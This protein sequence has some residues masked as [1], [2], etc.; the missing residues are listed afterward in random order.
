MNQPN[1]FA[2]IAERI[3]ADAAREMQLRPLGGGG[4]FVPQTVGQMMELAKMMA[5][6]G[7][8]VR[9]HL[10]GNP[11]ACLGICMQAARWE[12]DPYAV[13][14]K[15]FEVND[16]LGYESQLIAAVVNTRAPIKGRLKTRFH[17]DGDARRCIVSGTFAGEDEP[18]EVES[19][20]IGRIHPKNSP[21]WKSDPDQQLSYYT[22]RLWARREC[23]EVLLGVYDV[24]ELAAIQNHHGAQYA[25]DVTPPRPTRDQFLP[26]GDPP[27]MD[28]EFRRATGEVVLDDPEESDEGDPAHDPETGEVLQDAPAD[29]PPPAD[30][31]PY[32]LRSAD[33]KERAQ[34]K[35]PLGFVKALAGE[36]AAAGSDGARKAIIEANGHD[37]G[38]AY[39]D[40]GEDV[41]KR[42]NALY[43]PAP[44]G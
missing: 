21:L 19:P 8:T 44:E 41:Q 12:M 1:A 24:D 10:R 29:P 6:G 28:R 2:R 33:G 34:F 18:T 17:G 15:S 42:V 35:A 39:S 31:G 23:P 3:D 37:I 11:G 32:I 14:N 9:K 20:P 30:P 13:A 43:V 26:A 4:A 38:R 7:I 5:T 40:G 27:D 25:R 22:K 36:V 16:Q